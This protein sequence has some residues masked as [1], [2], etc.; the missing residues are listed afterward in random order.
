MPYTGDTAPPG[1]HELLYTFHLKLFIRGV[2][3]T[4]KTTQTVAIVHGCPPELDSQIQL[5]KMP[6]T[7]FP[8]HEKKIIRLIM[9]KRCQADWLLTYPAVNPQIIIMTSMVKYGWESNTNVMGGNQPLPDW[10]V[11]FHRRK[12]TMGTINPDKNPR[13][14]SPQMQGEPSTNILLKGNSIKLPSK[15]FSLYP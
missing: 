5:Q 15:F 10:E 8:A 14:V 1:T 6:H 7:L 13:L 4:P 2:P 9:T 12:H 11:L 3:E